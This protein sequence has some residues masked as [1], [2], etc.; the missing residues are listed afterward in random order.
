LNKSKFL[1]I[2]GRPD[3]KFLLSGRI[4]LTDEGS[5]VI[6]SRLDGSLGS[7]FSELKSAHNLPWTLK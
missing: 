3:G 2:D 4:L 6:L 7:D 5:D 1:D